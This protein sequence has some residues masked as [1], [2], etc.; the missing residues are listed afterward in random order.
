MR[1]SSSVAQTNNEPDAQ[2]NTMTSSLNHWFVAL[3]L[4][5]AIGA[6]YL[7]FDVAGRS[8]VATRR[9]RTTW[10]VGAGTTMGLGI[11]STH[12]IGMLAFGL[13]VG[14]DPWTMALS[15]LA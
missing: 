14:D 3:S 7:A 13:Q 10:L 8:T 11:W 4:L 15:L 9:K 5:A 1:W 2:A 6:S 12:Y